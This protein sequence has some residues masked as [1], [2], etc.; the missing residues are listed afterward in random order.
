LALYELFKLCFFK[1]VAPK[2]ILSI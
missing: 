2:S 1:K